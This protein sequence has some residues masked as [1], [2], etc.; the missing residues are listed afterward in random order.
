[1]IGRLQQDCDRLGELMKSVLAYSRPTDYEIE[2]VD[3]GVLLT[4]LVERQRP[5]MA[6]ARIEP[7]IHIDPSTP[8]VSG[9]PRALE[10]VFTNLVTNAIQAMGE[11]GGTLAVRIQAVAGGADRRFVRVE[12][13]D[14]GPGIPKELQ[15][16]LFQPFFTTKVDGTGLGLPITK[17]IVTAHKG[18]I[19]V[20]SFPGGTVFHVYLP[21]M[22]AA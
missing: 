15:E 13:A 20:T 19:Q 3:I 5:R 7:K 14:S 9:N 22:E 17:R 4:R 16:R 6:R 12:V 11:T 2:A 1:M 10:Q 21:S 8:L 18:S